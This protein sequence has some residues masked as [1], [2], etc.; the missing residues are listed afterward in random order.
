MAGYRAGNPVENPFG[1]IHQASIKARYDA[2]NTAPW[3]DAQR[4]MQSRWVENMTWGKV[5]LAEEYP[6]VAVGTD[7]AY[8]GPAMSDAFGK[9]DYLAPYYDDRAVKVA[10]S[11][12][13]MR[14]PGDFG[15]CLGSYGEKAASQA[16]RR[17][18]IWD[19]LF[20]GGNGLYYWFF[21]DGMNQAMQLSDKHAVYQCEAIEEIMGGIGELFTGCRR[22]FHPI[23]ILDSQTSGICDQLEAKGEPLS[24]QP[25]SIGAFQYALE[26]LGLNPHTITS[27][28]LAADWLAENGT[29]LLVL[30]GV[31]SMSEAE[32]AAVRSFVNAGGVVVADVRPGG[33]LPNGDPRADNP[34]DAVF[35]VS[36]DAAAKPLRLRGTLTGAASAGG[37]E[38]DFGKAL[39]D[40]RVSPT[41]A[42]ALGRVGEAPVLLASP[43]GA[44]R[45]FLL[46][47]SFS[48]YA[49]Y[50]V[51]GGDI[52]RPWHEVMKAIA[53]AAGLVPEFT[54]TSEGRETPG[55]E[56]SP[57]R[58]GRGYLLGVEDLG[59]G[60][61]VGPRRPFEIT[62]PGAYGIYDIR[63][64]KY[65]GRSQTLRADIPRQGHRAYALMPYGE[66][67]RVSASVAPGTV[68]PGGTVTLA[69]DIGLDPPQQRDLHVLR[70]EAFAPD[71]KT[72]FPFRRVLKMPQEGPL[73]VPFVT[74]LN[75]P[76]GE[77]RFVVTDISTGNSAEA[78]FALRQGGAQ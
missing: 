63:A 52:W 50:R 73:S 31:N 40:P 43:A 19:V 2:G 18:Q 69:T 51:E 7:A 76:P 33:R 32:I 16:G 9:L 22:L 57:F 54:V 3:V 5:A 56:I 68:A 4:F 78:R 38:M 72:F 8:Y 1:R 45:A 53:D 11:R 75:D 24:N 26:D 77:W 21:G 61:F 36:F 17:S 62:L 65:L 6:G 44:G 71:G 10:V 35:G 20:A 66:P 55:F 59:T 30:P 47:A 74:A 70:I 23:A 60:D 28:E 25:L 34:L 39:A 12:G 48:S 41:T 46:N 49:T 67:L 14:R 37:V 15:A 27:D 42:T 64:G 29:R 58:N 13:R